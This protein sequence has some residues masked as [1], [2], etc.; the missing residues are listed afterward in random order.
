M[1]QILGGDDL[2]SSKESSR[3]NVGWRRLGSVIVRDWGGGN[4]ERKGE[5]EREGEKTGEVTI[6]PYGEI[7]GVTQN[8]ECGCCWGISGLKVL[9]IQPGSPCCCEGELVKAFVQVNRLGFIMGSV[10][11]DIRIKLFEAGRVVLFNVA[12]GR[13]REVKKRT[14][15]KGDAA[16]LKATYSVQ[17]DVK[18]IVNQ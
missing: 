6:F 10:V 14:R 5:R 13:V 3:K 17:D 4:S 8:R 9:P 18:M 2:E 7:S 15:A 12:D 16:Q 11:R 1:R